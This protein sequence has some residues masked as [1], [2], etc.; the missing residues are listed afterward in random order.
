MALGRS[1]NPTLN[2]NTFSQFS[3]NTV[4]LDETMTL[5]GTV[6]K[7]F[8]LLLLVIGGAAVTWS[9]AFRSFQGIGGGE[10]MVPLMIAGMI[11]GLVTCLITVFKKEWSAITTPIYAILQGL[12]LGAISAFFEKMYPGI[13]VQ[14]VALTFGTLLVLL[15]IYKSG[16]ITV[17]ENLKLGIISATGAIALVYLTSWILA[18]FHMPIGFIYSSGPLG[19]IFSLVVVT[20]AALNLVL[21]F[22]FIEKGSDS[23][24][25]KYM[26]WYA[27]FGLMVT[28]IWLYIEIL[29]LL[30]KLRRK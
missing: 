12:F 27:A 19:I 13:V 17:T 14:A 18:M 23:G 20:I 6:N 10:L 11:G 28:L 25:P 24:A 4:S 1:N 30:A 29:K 5:Q 15:F 26:E 8:I 21:D 22:D 16:W 7:V 2:Q 9:M 3:G